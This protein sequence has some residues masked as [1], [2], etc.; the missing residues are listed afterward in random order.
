MLVELNAEFVVTAAAVV[1]VEEAVIA[2]EVSPA[3]NDGRAAAPAIPDACRG[4]PAGG[5]IA[6][7]R[8]SIK[9]VH[10]NVELETCRARQH[11]CAYTYTCT[12]VQKSKKRMSQA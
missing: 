6:D 3:E 12:Y 7:E 11:T 10:Q 8:Q 2:A 4:A 5:S 1:V 9:T